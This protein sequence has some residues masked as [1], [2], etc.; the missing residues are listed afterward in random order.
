[1]NTCCVTLFQGDVSK[2][3][4]TPNRKLVTDQRK[5]ITKVKHSA[6]NDVAGD[7]QRRKGYL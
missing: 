5:Y 2:H 4:L 3:V 7:I 6:N 1:M